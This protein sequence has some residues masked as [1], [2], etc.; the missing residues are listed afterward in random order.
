[1]YIVGSHRNASRFGVLRINRHD[2]AQLQAMEQP[3]AYDVH[4]IN[5]VPTLFY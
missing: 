1:M 3:M 5:Q 4:Q 2:G